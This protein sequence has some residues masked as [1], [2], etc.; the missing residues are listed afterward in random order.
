MSVSSEMMP[1]NPPTWL[2]GGFCGIIFGDRGY[3]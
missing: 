2:E 1:Q 3:G